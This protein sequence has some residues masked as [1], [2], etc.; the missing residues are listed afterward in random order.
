M[1]DNFRCLVCNCNTFQRKEAN[2]KEKQCLDCSN[3]HKMIRL[4]E[5]DISKLQPTPP[6]RRGF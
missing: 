3:D 1:F 5:S 4:S 6:F 2:Q